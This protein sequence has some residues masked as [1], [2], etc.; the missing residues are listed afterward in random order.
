ML[1]E[2]FNL[3]QRQIDVVTNASFGCGLLIYD[4]IVIPFEDRYPTDTKTYEL[5]NTK[6][7]EE[8]KDE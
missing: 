5:M 8:D 4:G 2:K 3:S 6:P 7:K 1:Y